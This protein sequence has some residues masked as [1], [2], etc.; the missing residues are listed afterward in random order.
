[1][2]GL[3]F[4]SVSSLF[5][6]KMSLSFYLKCKAWSISLPPLAHSIS[7]LSVGVS[8]IHFQTSLHIKIT[9]KVCLK[10][11]FRDLILF[12][13]VCLESGWRFSISYKFLCAFQ[14]PHFEHQ[15]LIL[16]L[17]YEFLTEI[18][19]SLLVGSNILLLIFSAFYFSTSM[20]LI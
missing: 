9:R 15:L 7:V 12:P 13:T 1:M 14:G 8:I 20:V 5:S 2:L 10:S 4:F 17:K 6:E 11:R 19:P 18:S 16:Q 3:L